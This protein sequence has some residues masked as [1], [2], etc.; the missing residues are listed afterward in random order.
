MSLWK[1]GILSAAAL[2]AAPAVQAQAPAAAQAQAAFKVGAKVSEASGAEVGTVTAVQGDTI[3]VKTDKNEGGVPRASF[4]VD[5]KGGG[6]LIGM[7]QAQLD[8]AFEKLKPD[9]SVGAT[10]YDPQGGVVGTIQDVDAAYATVKLPKNV[11]KLPVS[12]FAR[13]PNGPMVG[14]TASSL[15]AKVAAAAGA[16]SGG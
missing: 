11:A 7:S 6:L 14:E 4:A 16:K 2:L 1:Y 13:G 12:A 3:V 10:V 9:L 8:A 5:P 15:E